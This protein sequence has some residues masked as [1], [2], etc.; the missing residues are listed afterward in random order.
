MRSRK[1]YLG[2][3]EPFPGEKKTYEV[4]ADSLEEAAAILDNLATLLK[5]DTSLT[6]LIDKYQ[7]REKAPS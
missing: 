6:L 2:D 1:V 3:I 4:Q 7:V 5:P